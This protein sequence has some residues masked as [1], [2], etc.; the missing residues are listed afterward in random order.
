LCAAAR[1][2]A[3]AAIALMIGYAYAIEAVS[4]YWP[5]W[6]HSWRT[7]AELGF[8]A[9]ALAALVSAVVAAHCPGRTDRRSGPDTFTPR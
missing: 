5:V 6:P 3:L 7:V 2:L 9:S 1:V 8:L 4:P